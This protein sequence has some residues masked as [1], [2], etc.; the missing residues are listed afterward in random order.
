MFVF[1]NIKFLQQKNLIRVTKKAGTLRI[2]NKFNFTI[3]NL[4]E[5]FGIRYNHF[6][7]FFVN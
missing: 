4:F 5:F 6:P 7:S 2:V 3:D 1:T